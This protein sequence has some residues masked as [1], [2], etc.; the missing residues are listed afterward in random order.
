MDFMP[1]YHASAD[2][3]NTLACVTHLI[4]RHFD[5]FAKN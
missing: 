4:P 2:Q 1:F 3:N 5:W